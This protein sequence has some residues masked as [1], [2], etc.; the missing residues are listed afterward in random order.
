MR[1]TNRRL[2]QQYNLMRGERNRAIGERNR[3]IGERDVARNRLVYANNRVLLEFGHWDTIEPSSTS[4]QPFTKYD[5]AAVGIAA[6]YFMVG[7]MK[8]LIFL[9]ITF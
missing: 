1:T 6:P 7:K 9:L 5:M 8:I 2:Q 3:A 4:S